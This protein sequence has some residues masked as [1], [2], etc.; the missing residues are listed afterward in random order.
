[1][2]AMV[3]IAIVAASGA[4]GKPGAGKVGGGTPARLRG[5]SGMG[6]W[7]ARL[8]PGAGNKENRRREYP[9][10]HGVNVSDVPA[11]PVTSG[12]HRPSVTTQ[13]TAESTWKSS[14]TTAVSATLL[15]MDWEHMIPGAIRGRGRLPRHQAGCP[16]PVH[17][18]GG[19][20]G[21]NDKKWRRTAN[22]G[23]RRKKHSNL[24]SMRVG[25]AMRTT[26]P[27]SHAVIAGSGGVA[28]DVSHAHTKR[29]PRVTFLRRRRILPKAGGRRR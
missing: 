1:M 19:C 11:S 22:A 23:T 14:I 18:P 21:R 7:S 6:M 8:A 28:P 3:C 4:A 25:P 9:V 24:P 26:C 5:G 10:R 17:L 13:R 27:L 20:V 15:A 29:H 16:G 2:V 12:A